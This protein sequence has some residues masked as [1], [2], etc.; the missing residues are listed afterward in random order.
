MQYYKQ[1][2]SVQRPNVYTRKNNVYIK[3]F[4]LKKH[5]F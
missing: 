3:Q 4:F 2:K 1:H 5:E